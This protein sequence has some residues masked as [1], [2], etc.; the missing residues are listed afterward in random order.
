MQIWY[1]YGC[2]LCYYL[3]L[4]H[5][6]CGVVGCS[7]QEGFSLKMLKNIFKARTDRAGEAMG[8]AKKVCGPPRRCTPPGH[9]G[10]N[11]WDWTTGENR[12]RNSSGRRAEY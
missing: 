2:T 6:V 7:S 3:Q 9:G 8:R 1:Q 5:L 10:G 12:T 11:G 4:K